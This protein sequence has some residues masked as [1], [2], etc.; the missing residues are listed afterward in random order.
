MVSCIH[1]TVEAWAAASV[2][3]RLKTGWV[4]GRSR[5]NSGS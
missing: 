5:K 2:V 3:P 1:I 4:G